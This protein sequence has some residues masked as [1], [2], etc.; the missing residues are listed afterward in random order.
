MQDYGVIRTDFWLN[1]KYY[2][3]SISARCIAVY[4]MS[5]PHKIMWKTHSLPEKFI[6]SDLSLDKQIVR[7]A[8]QELIDARHLRAELKNGLLFIDPLMFRKVS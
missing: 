7:C 4:L 5:C 6:C 2:A 1:P 8:I 3:L